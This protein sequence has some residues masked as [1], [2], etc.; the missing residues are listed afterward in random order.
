MLEWWG[1]GVVPGNLGNSTGIVEIPGGEG[2]TESCPDRIMESKTLGA[3]IGTYGNN[4]SNGGYGIPQ[5]EEEGVQSP[6]AIYHVMNHGEHPELFF[7]TSGYAQL[8]RSRSLLI[9]APGSP[10]YKTTKCDR[11]PAPKAP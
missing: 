5:A 10:G 1:D 9:L 8:T 2:L 3:D 6:E 7:E 11:V 4:G